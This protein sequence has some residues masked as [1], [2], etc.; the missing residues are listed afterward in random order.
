M[1]RFYHLMR[2]KHDFFSWIFGYLDWFLTAWMCMLC[3]PVHE[4]P[5]ASSIQLDMVDRWVLDVQSMVMQY[6]GVVMRYPCH[7]SFTLSPLIHHCAPTLPPITH[8]GE[9]WWSV[10]TPSV[11]HWQTHKT[12]SQENYLMHLRSEHRATVNSPAG[13]RLHWVA[14]RSPIEI[15][16]ASSLSIPR[17]E[18]K[19]YLIFRGCWGQFGMSV[20]I[21]QR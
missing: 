1:W 19:S 17:S 5:W 14:R 12:I 4:H 2:M 21:H 16:S 13:D 18:I 7:P 10:K 8:V 9:H 3:L 20:S 15:K 6:C 11:N